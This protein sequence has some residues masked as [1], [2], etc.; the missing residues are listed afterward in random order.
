MAISLLL[1]LMLVGCKESEIKKDEKISSQFSL[2]VTFGNG[3]KGEDILIGKEGKVGFLVGSGKVGEATT[4]PIIANQTNKYMWHFWGKE[5]EISGDFKVIG[6]NEAGEEHP[7]LVSSNN[8]V[9]AYENVGMSP[10]NGADS[11]IPST[12]N[13]PSS[14]LW[15]LNVYFNDVFFEEIVVKVEGRN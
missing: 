14:G 15:T 2:P 5:D 10:K 1:L 4:L 3:V 8:S 11:H 6:V 13:F 7:I 9:W 12:L